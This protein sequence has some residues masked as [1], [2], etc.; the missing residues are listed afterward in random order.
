MRETESAAEARPYHHGDLRRALIDAARR[1]LETK[2]PAALSLRAVAREAGVSPAA[3]YHHFK[4]KGELLDAVADEGWR[5]LNEAMKAAGENAPSPR[6]AM[7][8]LGVAYVCFAREH[9][10]LYRV[11]YKR[12][13]DKEALPEHLHEGEDSAYCRTRDTL[14][15]A[16]ADPS[17][18]V[19]LELATI[20]AWCAAHGLAEIGGFQQF[21]H[22][23]EALGGEEAFFRGV[24]EHMGVFARGLND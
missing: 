19:G 20:A 8:S 11:M 6:A 3:P 10:A 13:R 21:A 24:F 7:P 2:G 18:P 12:S 16:G 9:P 4:D 5:I 22:L 14:I 23:K 1:I 17:D 15:A